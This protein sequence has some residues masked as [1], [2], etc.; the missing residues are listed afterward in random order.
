M[1][2]DGPF[3]LLAD[4]LHGGWSA[5]NRCMLE[6]I[7]V[8]ALVPAIALWVAPAYASPCFVPC[9]FQTKFEGVVLNKQV[10]Y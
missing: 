5:W 10:T 4:S 7:T 3:A 9:R 8:D 2:M 1:C 6:L